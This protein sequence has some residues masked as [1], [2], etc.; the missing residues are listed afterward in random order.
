LHV[1]YEL[2]PAMREPLITLLD[3]LAEWGKIYDSEK[4]STMPLSATK[5]E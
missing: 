4:L 3:H 1:E 2:A 5:S